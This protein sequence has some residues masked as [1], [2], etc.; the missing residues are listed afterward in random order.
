VLTN[1]SLQEREVYKW[2]CNWHVT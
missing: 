2:N 1:S